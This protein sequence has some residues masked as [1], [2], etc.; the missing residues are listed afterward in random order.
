[1]VFIDENPERAW[2][3]LAPYFLN[4]TREYSGWKREGVKRPS[5][6]DITTVQGLRNQNRF[7]IITPQECRE[8]LQ[9]DKNYTVVCHPLVGGLPIKRAWHYLHN[10]VEQVWAPHTLE[11]AATAQ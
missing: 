11:V 8:R 7:E 10:F 2:E 9:G 1:M 3:E 6:D 4:E 5:E